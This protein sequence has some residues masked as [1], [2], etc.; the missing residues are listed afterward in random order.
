MGGTSFGIIYCI[1]NLVN[2]KQCVGQT[3][4]SLKLR[5]RRHQHYAK[6][7][8]DGAIHRAIRKY[9]AENFKIEQIDTADSL[10]ELNN[11]EASHILLRV[12]LSPS[13]YNLTT[14]GDGC[15]LSEETKQKISRSGLGRIF[16]EEHIRKLVFSATGRIHSEKSKQKMSQSHLGYI[17]QKETK[18]KL[19]AAG[20]GRLHSEESRQKMSQARTRDTIPKEIR[21]GLIESFAKTHCKWGHIFDEINTYIEPSSL[22]HICLTCWYLRHTK[23]KMPKRLEC[24]VTGK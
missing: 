10:D 12:T 13:G 1:T 7:G 23:V 19:S 2:G 17:T 18:E 6:R 16:S 4:H 20:L 3:I 14:G 24:Y 8:S 9:G 21:Q 22:R 15:S 5:W 11:K